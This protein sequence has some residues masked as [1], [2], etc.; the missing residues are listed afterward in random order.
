MR[1]I[2]VI[3]CG[4][5]GRM[6]KEAVKAVGQEEGLRLVGE[7]DQGDDLALVIKEAL[8][9]VVVDFT[10]PSAVF[11]NAKCIISSKCHPV[12]GTSGLSLD[13]IKQLQKLA[14]EKK[15]GGIIAPNFA[16]GA[17]LMMKFAGMAAKY[18]SDVEIIELHHAAKVDA[19]SATALRTAQLISDARGSASSARPLERESV[20]GARGAEIDGIR[21]HSV[22]LPG[23]VAHQE[24]I[25][26]GSGQSLTIRHDSLDRSSFMPGVCLA[27]K[28]VIELKEL[29]VGL[30]NVM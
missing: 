29:V 8:P 30:E 5:K 28:K 20:R 3:V 23:L 6:G 17:V 27:C 2:R 26:G 14:K 16:L 1:E 11:D 12:I 24:V 19:P 18:F 21:L 15:I 10:V 13:Q 22:R 25:F 4:A 7:V 9:N